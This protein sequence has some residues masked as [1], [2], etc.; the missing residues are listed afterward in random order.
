V[1]RAATVT[2]ADAALRRG[3]PQCLVLDLDT[4]DAPADQLLT[5]MLVRTPG[6]PV[7]VTTGRDSAPDRVRML[8][9]GADDYLRKPVDLEE[10]VAR[11]RAVMRRSQRVRAGVA[12]LRHGPIE[13]RTDTRKVLWRGHPVGLTSMEYRLLE[14]LLRRPRHVH[15]RAELEALLHGWTEESVSNTVEVYVHH[16]RRKLCAPVVRTIR[17]T[18][19]QLGSIETLVGVARRG[20]GL[21]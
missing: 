15:T 12:V 9:L 5:S 18:G 19:Y 17:G 3:L 7:V 8:D 2:E 6:T 4:A 21:N 10:A 20:D 11:I 13:L 16:L 1:D 14:I